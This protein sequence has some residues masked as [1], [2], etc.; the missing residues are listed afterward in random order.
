ME[1]H[2]NYILATKNVYWD[3]VLV[4]VINLMNK[5]LTEA[6]TLEEV[7]LAITKMPEGKVPKKDS[8][9]MELF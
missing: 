2:S 6:F 3:L 8:L 5:D 9:P 4:K 7:T 1:P